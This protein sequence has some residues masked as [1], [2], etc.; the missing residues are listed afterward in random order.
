MP[1]SDVSCVVASEMPLVPIFQQLV[2][3][4]DVDSL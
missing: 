3:R 1:T 2:E 4:D